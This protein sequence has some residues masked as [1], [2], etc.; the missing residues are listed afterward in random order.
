[1][2]IGIS[3]CSERAPLANAAEGPYSAATGALRQKWDQKC[4]PRIGQS[5]TSTAAS[6]S[7]PQALGQ[8]A[9]HHTFGSS[10]EPLEQTY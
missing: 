2:N 6:L 4:I 9:L 5:L 7:P 3:A 1:M 8:L 10:L